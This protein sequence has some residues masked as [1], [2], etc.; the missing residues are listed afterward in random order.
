MEII[1]IIGRLENMQVV[2]SRFQLKP[3]IALGNQ[4]LLL[5]LS[6]MGMFLMVVYGDERECYQKT[7]IKKLIL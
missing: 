3:L 7:I 5:E 1:I 6:I 2:I 4:T